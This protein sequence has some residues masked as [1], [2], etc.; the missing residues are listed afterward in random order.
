M[1]YK[2][3]YIINY[4]LKKKEQTLALSLSFLFRLQR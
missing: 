2:A 3:V 4:V 1:L